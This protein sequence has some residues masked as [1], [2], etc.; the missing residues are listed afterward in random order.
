MGTSVLEKKNNSNDEKKYK[1]ERFIKGKYDKTFEWGW[2]KVCKCLLGLLIF[3]L[4]INLFIVPNN[5]YTGGILGM[6]QLIRTAIVSVFNINTN[7]DISAIIYYLINIPLFVFSYKRLSK[8]FFNRTLFGVTISSIFLAIIPIPNEPLMNNVLA[9]TLIGGM[10]SGIGV[11]MVLSTG[12]STGGID[13]IGI[14]L[15]QKNSVFTVGN[16]ALFFNVIIYGICGLMHGIE[17]MLYSMFY[18]VFETVMTDRNHM[19]NINSET[20]IFTKEHPEKIINF[21]NNNLKRGATYWEAVGGYTNTKTYIVYTV[22]SKYER[23][24]L[25]R[26]MDEF[27]KNAF[28]VGN[29]G[30]LVKGE[31]KKYLI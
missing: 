13:I 3:A 26:H 14:V 21:I 11:G 2:F 6:A 10:L 5:L 15:S 28:M 31:F 19:Q 16:I 29:D 18:A 23:M 9:N 8:V 30:L 1:L 25:E 12:S 22:L 24:R 20:F 7:I 4:G 27:D 17:T